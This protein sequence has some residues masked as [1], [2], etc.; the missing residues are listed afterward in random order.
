MEWFLIK[1]RNRVNFTFTS[2]K[3]KRIINYPKNET[4][5]EIGSERCDT[6]SLYFLLPSVGRPPPPLL[7][8]A[9][10]HSSVAACTVRVGR[11]NLMN[12]LRGFRDGRLRYFWAPWDCPSM[13]C[14]VPLPLEM[15]VQSI[16]C[17]IYVATTFKYLLH[18][19]SSYICNTV[20]IP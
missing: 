1:L 5:Q 14:I 6:L 19:F 20:D 3:L 12:Y 11:G 2:S 7:E 16:M 4:S 17:C 9:A 18:K 13:T 10:N 15:H 8:P